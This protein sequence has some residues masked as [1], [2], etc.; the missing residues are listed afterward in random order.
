M[1]N[2]LFRNRRDGTF[3]D[4]TLHS[5]IGSESYG[6]MGVICA[7]FDGAAAGATA[8][9][10]CAAGGRATALALDVRDRTAV[11]AAIGAAVREFGR[12]DVLID[13]AGVSQTA[14]FLDLDPGEWERIIAVNLTGMFHLGQAAARQ[15]VRQRQGGSIINITSQLAEVAR[16][17]RAAYVASKGGGRSLKSLLDC[18]N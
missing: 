5:G 11:D 4:V 14:G 16:P 8:A 2:R 10:V 13:C 7:D 18:G 12:L 17:E 1:Q 6:A 15:M 3:E 9:R